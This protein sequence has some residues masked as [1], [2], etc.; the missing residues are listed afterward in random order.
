[1]VG[2]TTDISYNTKLQCGLFNAR[3]ADLNL[4]D[5]WYPHADQGVISRNG[6]H[7]SDEIHRQ[8]NYYIKHYT[9]VIG[10]HILDLIYLLLSVW[11]FRLIMESV[12]KK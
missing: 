8:Q 5:Q 9:G 10:Q 3:Y 4:F 11:L 2:Y 1:M 12:N 7:Q 6:I